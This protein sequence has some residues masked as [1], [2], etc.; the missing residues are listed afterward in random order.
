M[1]IRDIKSSKNTKPEQNFPTYPDMSMFANA[2]MPFAGFPMPMLPGMNGLSFN[3]AFNFPMMNI[4]PLPAQKPSNTHNAKKTFNQPMICLDK[5]ND[6]KAIK[7]KFECLRE[8]NDPKF[9]TSSIKDADF[10]IIRSSNDDDFH[11]VGFD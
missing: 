11:K 4:T 5:Y 8:M 10:F 3:P 9:K 6:E 2:G 1:N 7:E